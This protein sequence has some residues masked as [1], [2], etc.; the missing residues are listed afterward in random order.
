MNYKSL[1]SVTLEDM[2]YLSGIQLKILRDDFYPQSGGGNKSRKIQYIINSVIKQGYSCI[3]TNGGIQSNHARATA[4]ACAEHNLRCSL[5]LHTDKKQEEIIAEG[6][7]LIMKIANAKIQFCELQ[8]LPNAM[9]KEMDYLKSEGCNPFYLWG[10]G[11]CLEGSLAYYDAAKSFLEDSSDWIPDYVIHASGT[12]TTQAGLIV[13]F[14]DQNIKVIGISIA[15][16]KER[17]SEIVSDSVNELVNYLNLSK[18]NFDIDFRDDWIFGGYEKFDQKIVTVISDVAKKTGILL[19]PTYTGKA[20]TALI[21]LVKSGEIKQGSR[22]LFW[23]T[24]GL[25]NLLSSSYFKG[26]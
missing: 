4:L 3:V 12:G 23:H 7:Y 2:D 9:D 5:I 26:L 11:H 8:D 10:G 6:N 25:L 17:G 22:V 16:E 1:K 18:S 13:G 14:A 21:D 20:F 24:G 19:D 15:R